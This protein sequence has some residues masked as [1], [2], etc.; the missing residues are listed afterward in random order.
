MSKTKR[1]VLSAFCF[2]ALGSL[3]FGIGIDAAFR[4]A[5]SWADTLVGFGIIM[6]M[7]AGVLVLAAGVVGVASSRSEGRFNWWLLVAIPASA[8]TIW[9]AWVAINL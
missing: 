9:G 6:L 5:G 8:L 3:L 4:R 1:L 7:I 2:A